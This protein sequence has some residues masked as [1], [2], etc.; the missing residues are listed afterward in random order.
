MNEIPLGKRTPG[1]RL[2]EMLP[3]AL[4]VGSFVVLIVLSLVKPVWA[5]VFLLAVLGYMF[6]KAM[7]LAF[8]SVTGWR[9]VRAAMATP[10]ERR[11]E[12]LAITQRTGSAE[13]FGG[14]ADGTH[15]L[16]EH[17]ALLARIAESPADFPVV[18]QLRHAVIVPAYNEP[19]DVIAPT[20]RSL[21]ATTFDARRLLVVFAYEERGGAGIRQTAQLLEHEFG[22]AF[23]AFLLVEHPA[24]LPSEVP[25]KGANITFAARSL[26]RYLDRE[27]IPHDHVIVTSLDCDNQPHPSY[28]DAVAYE[29]VLHDDRHA[30]SFQPVSIFTT[31]IWDAPAPSRVIAA[32]NSLWNIVTAVRPRAIRNFASHAQP[33][34]A[35]VAMDYWSTRTIVEDGHQFWRS[36]FHFDGR[37]RV[38]SVPLP[39]YQD[40]VRAGGFWHSM[41]A[42]FAQLRR[43]AYGASDVPFVAVRLFSSR[44]RVPAGD[45]A[46]KFFQLLEGHVTLSCVSLLIMFGPWAP[47]L[48]G[49]LAD[50]PGGTLPVFVRSLPLITG[51]VQQVSMAT[52]IVTVVISLALLP[53]RPERIPAWRTSLMV[54]QWL[55]LPITAIG[56]NA[57][58]ALTSQLQLA[59]GNYRE[60]FDVTEKVAA[61]PTPTTPNDL[62][63]ER[64]AA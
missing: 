54:A 1:Y 50:G 59:A 9:R 28:F 16:D 51:V 31:G 53:K 6:V 41:K 11:L 39:I 29:Y 30:M 15:R 33:M 24:G 49:G 25:G 5:G 22:E 64:L 35:L 17:R 44:R 14:D 10:W 38:A 4:S 43:W 32:G 34:D 55:L 47:V 58:S 26:R 62:A 57:A 19:Y 37:Y 60:V 12:E 61:E 20:L 21:Q 2:F 63:F 52:L 36:Y 45:G 56:F 48:L 40:V 7:R 46:L 18:D 27:R 23:G 13:G 42:Q 8:H 3:A